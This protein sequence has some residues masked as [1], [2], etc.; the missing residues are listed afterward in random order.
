[1]NDVVNVFIV[2]YEFCNGVVTRSDGVL[3][4]FVWCCVR[5]WQSFSIYKFKTNI[6][7]SIIKIININYLLSGVAASC[8]PDVV[9]AA[10]GAVGD[11]KI[12]IKY[13]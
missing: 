8:K 6:N 12:I 11:A 10:S 7:K 4:V 2:C 13:C 9:G 3:N 1:M 5:G